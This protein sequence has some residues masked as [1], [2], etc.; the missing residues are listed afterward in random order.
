MRP[1]ERTSALL[2]DMLSHAR[3]VVQFVH[4]KSFEEYRRERILM[5]A[6]QHV[7]LIIGEAASDIPK[8]FRDAH[9][10]VPWTAIIKQRHV[11]AHDYGS[12][13][14]E[15]IWRVATVH[16]PDMIKQLERMVPAPPPNDD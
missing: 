11:L 10:E 6:V 2:W 4:G 7:V 9:P 16:V 8:D 3:E 1:D 14:D 13:I 12:I 15:K 5:L